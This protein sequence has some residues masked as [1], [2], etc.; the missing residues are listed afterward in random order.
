MYLGDRAGVSLTTSCAVIWQQQGFGIYIGR[1]PKAVVE[2]W[3][4]SL[5]VNYLGVCLIYG[6]DLEYVKENGNFSNRRKI[7]DKF[8]PSNKCNQFC[9]LI[10][11]YFA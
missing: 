7:G 3:S 6:V 2:N 1:F 11:P 5:F 8:D 4:W 9:T 10:P